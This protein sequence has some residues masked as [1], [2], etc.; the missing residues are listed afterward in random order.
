M[1]SL[2]ATPDPSGHDVVDQEQRPIV[3][4]MAIS[5]ASYCV[6]PPH[7]PIPVPPTTPP[8]AASDVPERSVKAARCREQS[9]AI[10]VFL[11]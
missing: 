4:Q 9:C 7:V 2:V 11:N 1:L 10:A 5:I 3:V 8:V 6:L